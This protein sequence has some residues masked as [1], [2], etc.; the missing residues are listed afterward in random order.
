MKKIIPIFFLL[1]F[2]TSCNN[3]DFKNIQD[4]KTFTKDCI[5]LK[6]EHDIHGV[7]RKWKQS[8]NNKFNRCDRETVPLS[9][10]EQDIR[11]RS[12]NNITCTPQNI[13]LNNTFLKSAN[14]YYSYRDEKYILNL[15]PSSGE[16]RRILYGED[17]S[18]K[19][20]FS[21]EKGCFYVREDFENEPWGAIDYGI[22]IYLE[23]P[24]SASSNVS[25]ANEIYKITTMNTDWRFVSFDATSDWS[26]QFC[27]YLSTPW[28]FCTLLR[29]G[30]IM[31]HSN[32]NSA[33]KDQLLTEALLIRTQYNF[34]EMQENEFEL[35]WKLAQE[36]EGEEPQVNFSYAVLFRPDG[37]FYTE[38]AWI[39]YIKGERPFMPDTA[40]IKQRP[41]CYNGFRKVI[42]DDGSSSHIRGEICI[43]SEGEY[44]FTE[45]N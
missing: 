8:W 7:L 1:Y 37:P 31:F 32:V 10:Y 36:Y 25:M 44:V 22:Q 5:P 43:N 19:T 2:V 24:K 40:I 23:Q 33:Q 26:Y 21:K 42:L 29:N 16:Y 41:I 28:D 34:I 12:I 14:N 27:P 4:T 13:I 39:S 15:D 38:Q 18:G 3:N 11:R 45:F 20:V 35:A 9:Y 17:K 6:V 30:N